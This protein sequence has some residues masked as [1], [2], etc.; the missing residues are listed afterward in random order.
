YTTNLY[1]KE[2]MQAYNPAFTFTELVGPSPSVADLTTALNQGASYFNYRGF[3][4]MSDWDAYE[5]YDLVNGPRLPI[6][7]TI[8]CDTG[9]FAIGL[10]RAEAFLRAGTPQQPAGAIAAIGCST[11][12]THTAYNNLVDG[13]FY[14]AIFQ[15]NVNNI[16]VALMHAKNQIFT[17]YGNSQPEMLDYNYQIFN[18]MGDPTLKVLKGSPA[19]IDCDDSSFDGSG[20]WDIF[21]SGL[22]G[23]EYYYSLWSD[24]I[25]IIQEGRG[26][27]P[28][29]S[30]S[31]R[32]ITSIVKLLVT[33]ANH[34]PVL[35]TYMVTI[36]P[37]AVLSEVSFNTE[38]TIIP[39]LLPNTPCSL[40]YELT[41]TGIAEGDYPVTASIQTPNGTILSSI[42]QTLSVNSAG[43]ATPYNTLEILA[44][45]SD[46]LIDGLLLKLHSE[47]DFPNCEFDLP[48]LYPN[49]QITLT[50]GESGTN[51]IRWNSVSE[52]KVSIE[53]NSEVE[54]L[55][56]SPDLCGIADLVLKS[57]ELISPTEINLFYDFVCNRSLDPF[58]EHFVA[59]SVGLEIPF[60]DTIL[61][62]HWLEHPGFTITTESLS[63]KFDTSFQYC[64]MTPDMPAL[65]QDFSPQWI[66][67]TVTGENTWMSDTFEEDDKVC[68]VDL[69]FIFSWY[70]NNY[71]HISVCTNGWLSFNDTEQTTARNWR[72]PGTLGPLNMLAPF[73]DDLVTTDGGVFTSY[74]TTEDCFIIQWNCKS[75][76]NNEPEQFQVQLYPNGDVVYLYNIFNAVNDNQEFQHGSYFTTGFEGND[77]RTGF[78]Y[79]FNNNYNKGLPL[80]SN[81]AVI[82]IT[83]DL[84]ASGELFIGQRRIEKFMQPNNQ[85]SIEFHLRAF[86]G[87]VRLRFSIDSR[88]YWFRTGDGSIYNVYSGANYSFIFNF[89]TTGLSYG[90]YETEL[91]V[92]SSDISFNNIIIPVIL[93]VIPL[94]PSPDPYIQAPLPDIF[95]TEGVNNLSDY[96]GFIHLN[97]FFVVFPTGYVSYDY[98]VSPQI[99]GLVSISDDRLYFNN[100]GQGT[101]NIVITATPTY[102]P[103]S[104]VLIDTMTVYSVAD[105]STQD[106]IQ[107]VDSI[108]LSQNYPNPFS[109]KTNIDFSLKEEGLVELAIYNIRGQLVRKFDQKIYS[110]GLHSVEIDS[111]DSQGNSLSSGIYFYVLKQ[112]GNSLTK[113][114]ILMK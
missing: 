84:P 108:W 9:S 14:E 75:L 85:R 92:Y 67:I 72:L 70:G 15:N 13:A 8:T 64:I 49:P 88:I 60:M 111:R 113:K 7:T 86:G 100:V 101:Y 99:E 34:K 110:E 112:N 91:T 74:N 98:S 68:T 45:S 29:I 66:D 42:G 3:L 10:S 27:T 104:P 71:S 23:S 90:D 16:G 94:I 106:D 80:I 48:I 44:V 6:V 96:S 63:P 38:E 5:A 17:V 11:A 87:N 50:F 40:D 103:D 76:F 30:L 51:S 41:T 58:I 18:L 33:S 22:Y 107:P 61:E 1:I 97:D 24:T 78:E 2:M 26:T 35:R 89:D 56:L 57:Y 31:S 4:G 83:D 69:P 109:P 95:A 55:A 25:G 28:T 59:V 43:I 19:S 114:M 47:S 37:D 39:Y 12:D 54:D 73:W 53:L 21:L 81:G 52:L 93:H 102:F 62:S 46:L 65:P 77:P 20:S 82:L 79:A 32:G 36:A 105:V